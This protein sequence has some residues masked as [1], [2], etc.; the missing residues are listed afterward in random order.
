M[1]LVLSGLGVVQSEAQGPYHCFRQRDDE[2]FSARRRDLTDVE[3][4]DGS[5]AGKD[6]TTVSTGTGKG[7]AARNSS[8]RRCTPYSAKLWQDGLHELGMRGQVV[9][10]VPQIF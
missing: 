8:I 4:R 9:G 3:S 1:G 5:V 6:A 2:P 10:S 7:V